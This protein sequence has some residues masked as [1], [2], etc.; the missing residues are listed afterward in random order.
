MFVADFNG[1]GK[2]DVA[3]SS[4]RGTQIYLG[5]G[6]GT[7]IEPGTSVAP[8]SCEQLVAIGDVNRDGKPDLICATSVLLGKGDGTFG[9]ARQVFGGTA[10]AGA[11]FNRDGQPHRLVA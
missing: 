5:R 4:G 1:D 10:V 11:G 9:A 3:F 7:F 6:D 2:G 8:D